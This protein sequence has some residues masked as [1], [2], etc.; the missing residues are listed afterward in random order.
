MEERQNQLE[1]VKKRKEELQDEVLS[2]KAKMAEHDATRVKNEAL[3]EI[4]QEAI[5]NSQNLLAKAERLRQEQED[6]IKYLNELILNAKCHAIRDAQIA[7]KKVVAKEMHE[8]EKRLDR[9]MEKDRQLQLKM[10][11]EISNKR[12]EQQLIG[13]NRLLEQIALNEQEKLLHMERKDAECRAINAHNEQ[14]CI[15]EKEEM[16]KLRERQ[17]NL[18]EELDKG[19]RELLARKVKEKDT[20]RA[21]EEQV[22]KF[23][24]EKAEREAAIEAEQERVR[25]EKER[26]VARLRAMQEREQDKK[27]EMDA[28]RAKRAQEAAERQWR[29]KAAEAAEKTAKTQAMLAEAR[30]E[31]LEARERHA[32]VQAQRERADFERVLRAQRE[33]QEKDLRQEHEAVKNRKKFAEEVRHQIRQKEGERIAQRNAFFEEGV[34]LDAEAKARR[35]K[36]DALKEEKLQQL[37]YLKALSF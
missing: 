20:E 14:M 6:E 1:M 9:M 7:E 4:E 18:R 3:S 36:L 21:L 26:E 34:Q 22:R 28:L 24:Q 16:E 17:M 12:K 25:L 2:R 10:E 33:L 37:R 8:E 19:N 5:A 15:E 35:A 13:A 32:A 11:E 29:Q 27:A 23:Q 30:Q 31:Q